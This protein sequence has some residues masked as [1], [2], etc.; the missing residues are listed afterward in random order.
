MIG[1]IKVGGKLIEFITGPMEFVG[2]GM[3]ALGETNEIV[4]WIW[5]KVGDI[6]GFHTEGGDPMSPEGLLLIWEQFGD[7]LSGE[8][9]FF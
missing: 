5:K 8:S 9:E 3:I 7:I 2:K 4:G 1:F 6:F